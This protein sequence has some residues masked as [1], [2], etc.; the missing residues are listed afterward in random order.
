MKTFPS[1]FS[2]SWSPYLVAEQYLWPPLRRNTNWLSNH[3]LSP[4]IYIF[5]PPPAPHFPHDWLGFSSLLKLSSSLH[6]FW[7]WVKG[8][9]V[10]WSPLVNLWLEKLLS[11]AIKIHYR[12]ALLC[13]QVYLPWTRDLGQSTQ[14][15]AQVLKSSPH[16]TWFKDSAIFCSLK[17]AT[18]RKSKTLPL[19]A[20]VYSFSHDFWSIVLA[21]APNIPTV[22][23]E[24]SKGLK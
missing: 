20:K 22:Q 9:R 14:N 6:F 15:M 8:D 16:K 23:Y 10:R 1:V 11:S 4:M 7:I 13:C 12:G 5:R 3:A 21:T 19:L 2:N 24:R 17:L 18:S